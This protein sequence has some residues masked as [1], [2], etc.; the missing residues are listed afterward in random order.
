M[1]E[2]IRESTKGWL[3]KVILG[4][5]TIP[6]ALFGIDQYLQ[7]AGSNVPVAKID[8]TLAPVA[9]HHSAVHRACHRK[10]QQGDAG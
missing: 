10:E 4:L 6:F 9:G 7:G 3:A 8:I 1:L 5:I 2:A